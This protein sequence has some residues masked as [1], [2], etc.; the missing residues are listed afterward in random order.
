LLN[1][2]KTDTKNP[3]H[4]KR[5]ENA[6]G[7]GDKPILAF[8]TKN[9]GGLYFEPG[10][11]LLGIIFEILARREASFSV[12]RKDYPLKEPAGSNPNVTKKH[13]I[14]KMANNHSYTY[15]TNN[16]AS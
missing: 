14:L 8:L 10:G 11:I 6:R 2:N 3:F 12:A 4:E 9:V 5:Q 15:K 1:V 16:R 7:R 13:L